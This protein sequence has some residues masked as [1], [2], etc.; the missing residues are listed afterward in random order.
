MTLRPN[1]QNLMILEQI[2]EDAAS[3]LTLQFERRESGEFALNIFGD[4][5]FGNRTLVFDADGAFAGGGTHLGG[6]TRP[7][8]I[9][10][11][12]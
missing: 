1:A 6:C 2:I 3:G 4:I 5:P 9:E 8:W 11:D 7:N 12:K 10:I